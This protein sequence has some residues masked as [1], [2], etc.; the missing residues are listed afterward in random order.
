MKLYQC[1][2]QYSINLG[3]NLF[4]NKLQYC[5]YM[6]PKRW[7]TT[8]L[9]ENLSFS[10]YI[11]NLQ[12]I[13]LN[14]FSKTFIKGIKRCWAGLRSL[15][16]IAQILEKPPLLAA[17]CQREQTGIKSLEVTNS[18]QLY[19]TPN[20]SSHW[21]QNLMDELQFRPCIYISESINDLST[22]CSIALLSI[23]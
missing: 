12:N 5:W 3:N 22:F 1:D 7:A 15:Q 6:K 8:S 2:I 19:L 23:V 21:E 17:R 9:N 16:K 13:H 18:L 14:I 10:L 4:P 20:I 11:E